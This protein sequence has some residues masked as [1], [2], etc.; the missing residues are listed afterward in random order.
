MKRGIRSSNTSKF[1]FEKPGK[2]LDFK[3]IPYFLDE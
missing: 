3:E 2:A 1:F